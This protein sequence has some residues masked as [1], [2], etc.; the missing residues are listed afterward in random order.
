MSTFYAALKMKMGSWDYYSVKMRMSQVANE[1]QF[2]SEVNDDKTLDK[3]IQREISR[4]RAGTQI[5]NYLLKNDERFFNSLVVAALDGNPQFNPVTIEDIPEMRMVKGQFIDTFGVLTFD[6]TIKTY[7]LDGQ[8][9]L[10]AIKQLINDSAVH[11]PA[12]GFSEETINVIFVV[13]KED[14]TRDEFLKS[15][16]RL[17]SSLNRHAKTTAANTNI[18]MDEDDRFA[19]VT[20]RLFSDA[21]FFKW[22]G[23]E[24]NPRIDTDA[25]SPNMSRN[26][27][28]WATLVGLY[29]MN[30]SL[31]WDEEFQNE[32][33]A[34]KSN[35]SIIQSTPLDSEIDELYTYLD[36]IWDAMVSILPDIEEDPT[37]KRRPPGPSGYAPDTVDHLLF[38]PIGQTDILAPL[39]RRLMNNSD[40]NK[41]STFSEIKEA[42]KPLSYIDWDLQ[43]PIWQG[44]LTVQDPDEGTWKM[45]SEDA[46]K[47]AQMG[48]RILLWLC[49]LESYSEDQLNDLKKSWKVWLIPTIDKTREDEIFIELSD[50]RE[51]I[52]AECYD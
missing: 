12:P 8:H 16:R 10:F 5:V 15:Y 34:F 6:D 37:K 18:I 50:L 30:I 43:S 11:N 51:K 41:E 2:A 28:A 19:I 33:G 36:N 44:L 4:G 35:H 29:K 22:D 46:K 13:P 24:V 52:L 1:I 26:S 25:I 3:H 9:R 32:N 14:S 27:T 47:C 17:F 39:A 38:R 42:L 23:N 40:I 7:A 45:R 20:R 21:E 49:G 48:L 31:L